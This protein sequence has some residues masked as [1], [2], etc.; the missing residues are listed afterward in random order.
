MTAWPE[1]VTRVSVWSGRALPGGCWQSTNAFSCRMNPDMRALLSHRER[2]G[3]HVHRRPL[4]RQLGALAV[5]DRD[6]GVRDFDLRARGGL[7]ENPAAGTV[8][9]DEAVVAH[10]LQRDAADARRHIA[11]QRRR[12]AVRV[13]AAEPDGIVRVAPRELH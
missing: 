10:G 13:V 11:R 5:V 4:Q 6:A 3:V 7:D 2:P 12:L 1:T 9:D 8:P